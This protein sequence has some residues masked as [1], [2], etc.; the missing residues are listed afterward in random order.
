M[1]QNHSYDT[2]FT[3]NKF[4]NYYADKCKSIIKR[5]FQKSHIQILV[6]FQDAPVLHSWAGLRPQREPLRLEKETLTFD[7][8]PLQ[9]RSTD[10]SSAALI[11]TGSN[12]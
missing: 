9:V 2:N 1:L 11:L 3:T 6:L 10:H 4:Y 12:T 8:K 5:A 7:G